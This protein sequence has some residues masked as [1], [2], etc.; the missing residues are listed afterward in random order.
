MRNICFINSKASI[1]HRRSYLHKYYN[2]TN[3]IWI[4]RVQTLC[5]VLSQKPLRFIIDNR[6]CTF[7]VNFPAISIF[8]ARILENIREY[9]GSILLLF[10]FHVHTQP[11]S[12]DHAHPVTKSSIRHLDPQQ[13]INSLMVYV[14]IMLIFHGYIP[15]NN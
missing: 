5:I 11:S 7:P 6:Q 4:N 3:I 12:E 15:G 1:D 13:F 10:S 8:S 14:H 2:N 9:L